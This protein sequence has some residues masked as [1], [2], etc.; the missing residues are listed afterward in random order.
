MSEPHSNGHARK[1]SGWSNPFAPSASAQ[2]GFVADFTVLDQQEA[3]KGTSSKRD[4]VIEIDPDACVPNFVAAYPYAAKEVDELQLAKGDLIFVTDQGDDGWFVGVNLTSTMAGTF[5]GNFVVPLD[6]PAAPQSGVE[7][8]AALA[9]RLQ[10]EEE[11]ATRS[12][13]TATPD[14]IRQDEIFARMLQEE[15][16]YKL[17]QQSQAAQAS[18][19]SASSTVAAHRNGAQA[20]GDGRRP[21]AS[22]SQMA[23][24]AP[25][26]ARDFE[27][28][29]VKFYGSM[30]IKREQV[31][32]HV[33]SAIHAM[34]KARKA[35]RVSATKPFDLQVSPMGVKL[36]EQ[37]VVKKR[38]FRKKAAQP[39]E[40][41]STRY[42]PIKNVA[43]CAFDPDQ[44]RMFAFVSQSTSG[45]QFAVHV[46]EFNQS[47]A[48]IANAF[49]RAFNDAQL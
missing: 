22:T 49:R 41:P 43:H 24:Y 38:S 42:F 12:T 46:F 16:D 14:S 5:P 10:A 2:G 9:R 1:P 30:E 27:Q 3:S 20:G 33:V 21:T 15:E 47:A 13:A 39:K 31:Q 19:P 37:H 28:F 11:A 26:N 23:G 17:A 29:S 40:P 35:Q 25:F 6:A 18:A 48:Q 44:H 4:S 8:D 34:Q 7:D 32:T 45:K 36:I